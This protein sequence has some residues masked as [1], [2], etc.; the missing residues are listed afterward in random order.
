[1]EILN[2]KNDNQILLDVLNNNVN[3]FIELPYSKKIEILKKTNQTYGIN[4]IIT[5]KGFNILKKLF[6][7]I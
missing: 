7:C 3:N 1:M 6:F 2:L 5:F 4:K